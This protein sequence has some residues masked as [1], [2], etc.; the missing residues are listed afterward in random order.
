[1]YFSTAT[2]TRSSI[3]FFYRRIF[4]SSKFNT[5]VWIVLSMVMG[6]FIS[7]SIAAVFGCQPISWFWNPHQ[8]GQCMDEILFFKVNGIMNLILDLIVLLLP[9]PMLWRLQMYTKKKIALSLIFS[10]GLL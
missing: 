4:V 7:C 8:P 5:M 10:L 2:F 6:Y 1:M 9:I 3:L